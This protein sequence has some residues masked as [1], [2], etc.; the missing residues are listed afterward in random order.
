MD[1]KDLR[2]AEVIGLFYLAGPKRERLMKITRIDLEKP[3][4]V[5]VVR[6]PKSKLMKKLNKS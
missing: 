4:T 3:M 5:T 1:P 6:S 2:L